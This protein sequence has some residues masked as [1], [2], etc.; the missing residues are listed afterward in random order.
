MDFSVLLTD[1]RIIVLLGCTLAAFLYLFVYYLL[2]FLK[3][4]R[5]Q[6]RQDI[7]AG[8]PLREPCC[9]IEMNKEA[10]PDVSQQLAQ[11]S[12][13]SNTALQQSMAFAA[14][15]E[16]IIAGNISAPQAAAKPVEEATKPVYE[17]IDFSDRPHPSVSVVLIVHNDS[18]S[19]ERNLPFL[20]EQEYPDF[21]IVVV[22][23]CSTD[24]SRYILKV[25]SKFYTH[26]KVVNFTQDVNLFQGLKYPLSIGIRSASKQVVLLTEIDCIPATFGWIADMMSAYTETDHQIVMGYTGLN[27]SHNLLGC[28]QQYD[29]LVY[30]CQYLSAALRKHPYTGCGRNLS[31]RK[32]F[33]FDCNGFINHYVVSDGA[34]DMFINQNATG[35]NARVMLRSNSFV[36]APSRPNFGKWHLHRK[37]RTVTRRTYPFLSKVRLILYPLSLVLFY[38][39]LILLFLLTPCPWPVVAGLLFLKLFWQIICEAQA[40]KC[41]RLKGYHWF[42][43]LFELY[44]LIANLIL[45]FTPLRNKPVRH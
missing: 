18:A 41:F 24:E 21:E 34:D 11:A 44:F 25:L 5:E 37:H 16:Q 36:Y 23:Y 33:F 9:P 40:V 39:T 38:T 45:P 12:K 8:N 13:S 22:N 29:N 42:S 6:H 3:V 20:L 30:Q 15:E 14:A 27:I 32:K 19:L 4:G 35:A 43:P 31:Y 7:E 1:I 17:R 2:V 26:L 10:Q 28:L